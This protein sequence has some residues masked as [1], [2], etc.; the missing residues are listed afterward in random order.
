MAVLAD[1]P[2]AGLV[3]QVEL[4]ATFEVWAGPAGVMR[5][6]WNRAGATRQL[7]VGHGCGGFGAVAVKR[8]ETTRRITGKIILLLDYWEMT[9]YDS[10]F[11][12]DQTGWGISQRT[13]FQEFE[14][15]T[16][17]KMVAMGVT[18]ARMA[19]GGIGNLHADRG[20]FNVLARKQGFPLSPPMPAPK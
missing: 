6:D 15:I 18:V 13:N 14:I 16:R 7:V 11:R 20:S 2:D 4:G 1:T 3:T 8:W 10:P 19:M 17:S 9:G 12:V 5:L